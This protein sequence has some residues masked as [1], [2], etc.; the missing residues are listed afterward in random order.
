MR[1][2]AVVLA[3]FSIARDLRVQ[4]F[5]MPSIEWRSPFSFVLFLFFLSQVCTAFSLALSPGATSRRYGT[6]VSIFFFFSS[7]TR[8]MTIEIVPIVPY[9]FPHLIIY[10]RRS[11]RQR[12]FLRRQVRR[13]GFSFIFSLVT[14]KV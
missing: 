8:R 3:G 12:H 14:S 10:L 11:H 2:L 1:F 5:G 9:L 4:L 6:R 7:Q 13:Y